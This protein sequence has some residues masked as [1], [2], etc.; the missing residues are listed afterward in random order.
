MVVSTFM[1]A[2]TSR[3]HVLSQPG[4]RAGLPPVPPKR[5]NSP[6]TLALYRVRVGEYGFQQQTATPR[7]TTGES[8][9]LH[10]SLLL[11]VRTSTYQVLLQGA[12]ANLP[13][14]TFSLP[15][16]ICSL[17]PLSKPH[18]PVAQ[19][20]IFSFPRHSENLLWNV[21]PSFLSPLKTKTLSGSS[22]LTLL[23]FLESSQR[24]PLVTF[25]ARR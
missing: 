4:L 8:S 23:R 14:P 5:R 2:L 16:C 3:N 21:M 19:M 1:D 10:L 22:L 11:F 17:F 20:Q 9:S 18:S 13:L 25:V 12:T 15:F 24:W 7:P 6:G